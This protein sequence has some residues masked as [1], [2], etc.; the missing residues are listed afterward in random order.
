MK[1]SI[2]LISFLDA[3]VDRVDHVARARYFWYVDSG[4]GRIPACISLRGSVGI[5][6]ANV[7]QARRARHRFDAC[8]DSHW[9]GRGATTSSLL[10]WTWT[11]RRLHLVDSAR[12]FFVVYNVIRIEGSFEPFCFPV[13]FCTLNRLW[14]PSLLLET[15]DCLRNDYCDYD[16]AL[17]CP[18]VVRA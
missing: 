3:F 10:Y 8:G 17:R 16:L 13:R 6:D 12:T 15:K 7:T 11:F 5:C 9:Q 14:A 1:T 4:E 18:P 2:L